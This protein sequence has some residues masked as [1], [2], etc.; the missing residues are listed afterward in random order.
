MNSL[1]DNLK[2]GLASVFY[3][4]S[5]DSGIFLLKGLKSKGKQSN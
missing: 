5:L 1:F 4:Y 2:V 3:Q